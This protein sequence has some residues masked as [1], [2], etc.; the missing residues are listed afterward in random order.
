MR[1][2]RRSK[3]TNKCNK[4]TSDKNRSDTRSTSHCCS[5]RELHQAS[6]YRVIH[7][8]DESEDEDEQSTGKRKATG[9]PDISSNATAK[10]KTTG[11]QEANKMK[12]WDH[13][14]GEEIWHRL[15]NGYLT[16]CDEKKVFVYVQQ[17]LQHETE[18]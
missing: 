2:F 13:E 1:D 15:C 4:S 7:H 12:D 10:L 17:R 3:T 5:L 8:W 18:K 6:V 16:G 11:T 9:T 14:A